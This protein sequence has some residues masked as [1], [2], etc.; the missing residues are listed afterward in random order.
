MNGSNVKQILNVKKDEHFAWT[1]QL[2]G[3]KRSN[4]VHSNAAICP[5]IEGQ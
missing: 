2:R 1:L 5:C 4:D 3:F